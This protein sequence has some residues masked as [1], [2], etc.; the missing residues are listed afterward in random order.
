[1][2][3]PILHELLDELDEFIDQHQMLVDADPVAFRARLH[4]FVVYLICRSV[5]EGRQHLLR[6]L[7]KVTPN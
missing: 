3:P 4:R 1:M 2:T 7:T 5:R 6:Q